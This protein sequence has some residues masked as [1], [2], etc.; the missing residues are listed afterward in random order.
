VSGHTRFDWER[1]GRTGLP[2][3]VY[4]EG[5]SVAQLADI[6]AAAR[7]RG[8]GLLATRLT[9]AKARRLAAPDLDHDPVSRT[10]ILG[11][12]PD[13]DAGPVGIVAAGTSDLPVAQEAARAARFLGVETRVFADVGVAGLWRLQA[14]LPDLAHCR[15]LIGVAGMEGALFPVLAGL[16]R[17]P[18]IAVPTSVGYGMA[19]GGR[20]ALSTALAACAPGILV[21]NID[22]G[23]GAAAAAAK[24]LRINLPV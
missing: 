4:A 9:A 1:E 8:Q 12:L 5:K 6:L 19:E 23:F 17:Q 13:C 14:I 11:T 21:V 24:I 15:L 20:A 3:V 10:A 2:E 22:N 7:A 16:V 18:V